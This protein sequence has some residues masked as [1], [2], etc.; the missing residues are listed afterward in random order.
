MFK[1]NIIENYQHIKLLKKLKNILKNKNLKIT[2]LK[3]TRYKI[4]LVIL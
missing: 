4:A 1:I 3:M 2:L